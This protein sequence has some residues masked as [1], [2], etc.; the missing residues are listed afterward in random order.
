MR[1]ILMTL[2]LLGGCALEATSPAPPPCPERAPLVDLF[3]EERIAVTEQWAERD[4]AS[5]L[6]LSASQLCQE[7][8][9]LIAVVVVPPADLEQCPGAHDHGCY[10]H[11]AATA[12]DAWPA[13]LIS[14]EAPD[15]DAAVVQH[16][17]EVLEEC[18]DSHG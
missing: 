8:M 12:L 13:V 6:D 7:R 9:W 10:R 1:I 5:H 14:D 17:T 18:E 11:G 3:E 16:L 2:C 4:R 15:I